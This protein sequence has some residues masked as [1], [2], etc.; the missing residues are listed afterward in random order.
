MEGKKSEE[1]WV[2]IYTYTPKSL[3][4]M[5]LGWRVAGGQSFPLG[6]GI[7]W[8]S[9]VNFLL[10]ISKVAHMTTNKH[11]HTHTL[12]SPWN[13]MKSD[14]EQRNRS[15]VPL[16]TQNHPWGWDIYF[17]FIFFAFSY[18][19]IQNS[20]IQKKSASS[21]LILDSQLIKAERERERYYDLRNL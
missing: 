4:F 19:L 14:R 10:K 5:F 17:I 21:H 9:L 12:L 2:E 15:Q 20:F 6:R 8:W 7:S 18:I 11:T 13:W 1:S 16:R 3:K